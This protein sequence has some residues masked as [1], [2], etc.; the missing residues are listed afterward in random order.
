MRYDMAKVVVERPR[1]GSK[2]RY[3]DRRRSLNDGDPDL[4]RTNISMRHPYGYERKAFTDLLG[5]LSGFLRSCV[6]RRWDDVYSEIAARMK[7]NSTVQ[8][9]ILEHVFQY[10]SLYVV[11]LDNGEL[12][13]QGKYGF[14]RLRGNLYSDMYVDPDSGLLCLNPAV[15]DPKPWKHRK[16]EGDPSRLIYGLQDE[17]L[18]VNGCWHRVIFAVAPG[19]YVNRDPITGKETVINRYMHDIVTAE[20]VKEGVYRAATRQLDSKTLRRLGL[21]NDVEAA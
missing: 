10:V 12:L 6:G 4:L 11:R 7:G 15:D 5:P 2:W 9:H 1:A 3:K 16:K 18:K 8:R 13:E 14:Y 17:V 20:N 21:T 19:P